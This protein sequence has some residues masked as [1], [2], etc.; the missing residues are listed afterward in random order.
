MCSVLARQMMEPLIKVDATGREYYACIRRWTSSTGN[1]TFT[2]P[3]HDSKNADFLARCF[4]LGHYENVHLT[5]KS[6]LSRWGPEISSHF[7][8]R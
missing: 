2:I 3:G 1:W 8:C 4:H 7:R 6:G 5:F